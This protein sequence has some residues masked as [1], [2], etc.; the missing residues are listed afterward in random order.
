MALAETTGFV[1]VEII[2]CSIP[3][4]FISDTPINHHLDLLAP[5][6][7]LFGQHRLCCQS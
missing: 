1:S 7:Y 4:F 6:H 2:I 3:D 5:F